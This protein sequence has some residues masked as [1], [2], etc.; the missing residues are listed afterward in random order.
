MINNIQN[1]VKQ[2]C[3]EEGVPEAYILES[4]EEGLKA[5]LACDAGEGYDIVMRIQN[6][7]YGDSV[8]YFRRLKVVDSVEDPRVEISEKDAR[9]IISSYAIGDYVEEEIDIKGFSRAAINSFD[10]FIKNKIKFKK[11][12]NEFE[13]LSSKVGTNIMCTVQATTAKGIIV[14]INGFE[15]IITDYMDHNTT[16]NDLPPGSRVKAY[17]YKVEELYRDF[18]NFT[19]VDRG[20]RDNDHF[21]V[22]LSRNNEEF[23]VEL[24]KEEVPEIR[25]GLVNIVNIARN[26]GLTSIVIVKSEDPRKKIGEVEVCVGP[27]GHRVKNIRKELRGEKIYILPWKDMLAARVAMVIGYKDYRDKKNTNIKKI[28][29]HD[30][31]NPENNF[32][33]VMVPRQDVSKI[34]GAGGRNISLI[35]RALGEKI[36][37]TSVDDDINLNIMEEVTDEEKLAKFAEM[38]EVLDL[39]DEE[40]TA[41]NNF[42]FNSIKDIANT[43]FQEFISV[44]LPHQNHAVIYNRVLNVKN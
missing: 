8:H 29:M 31:D 7:K 38:K 19:A 17:L 2:I 9:K 34:I 24:F 13:F 21:Q 10:A 1:L 15:G 32:I 11:K 39:T 4:I 35:S 37:I 26:P 3:M 23:L 44:P 33:E 27:E 43:P 30:D 28:I 18:D 20:H 14:N 42:G 36:K 6:N 41:L 25:N 40:V 12:Q 22:Y 5:A 16:A